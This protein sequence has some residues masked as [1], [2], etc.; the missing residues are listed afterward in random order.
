MLFS[1][2]ADFYEK[3]EATTKRLEMIDL[4]V[5]LFLETPKEIIDKVVYLTTG[6]IYPMFVP[7]ELGIS[8]KLAMRSIAMIAGVSIRDVENT[9]KEVGDIGLVA[10][11]FTKKKKQASLFRTPLTVEVVYET[12]DK[13]AK[14]SGEGS[15]EAKI[16]HLSKLLLDGTPKEAKYI[17]RMVVGKLRLGI[18]D[19][20]ILDALAVAFTGSRENRPILERAY[21]ITSDLGLIAKVVAT[22]GLNSVKNFKIT[23][24]R[25]IR[26]MLAQR[27]TSPEE[28][29]ERMGGRCSAEYK[30]DGERMQ[31]H[32]DGSRVEI[33]SRRLENITSQYPDAVD[34]IRAHVKAKE[35]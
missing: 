2:I 13:I 30:L 3:I 16:R 29:L 12:L 32:K 14:E 35:A 34:L 23:V 18:A 31:I 20:T 19:Y 8:E 24:G 26:M 25:P 4:L 22:E 17:A 11:I 21:N 10:E 6:R 9:F 27:A 5:N 1:K 28:I 7:I 15:V 33:F